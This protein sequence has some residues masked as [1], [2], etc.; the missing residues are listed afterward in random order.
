MSYLTPSEDAQHSTINSTICSA[1]G[2]TNSTTDFIPFL[3]AYCATNKSANHATITTTHK[4][5][6]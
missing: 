4:T 5:T 6:N 3:S 1:V 2:T